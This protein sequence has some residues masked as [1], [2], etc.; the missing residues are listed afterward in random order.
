METCIIVA[1]FI[2]FIVISII[3]AYLNSPSVKGRRGELHVGNQLVTLP[4]EYIVLNDVVLPTRRGTTQIDHI[5]VSPYGIFGIE[6]KNYRGEIYGDDTREKWTQMIITDVTYRKSWKTYTYVTKSHFYNPVKQSLGHIYSLKD[7]LNDFGYIP[8]IPVVVFAGEAILSNVN[9]KYP[10]VYIE[11]LVSTIRCYDKR[12]LSGEQ[13]S[14]IVRRIS[15]I[16][17]RETVKNKDHIQNIRNAV[18]E[19]N[20]KVRNGICPRC[21]GQLVLRHGKYG[22]FYGCSNYPK[23]K[24]TSEA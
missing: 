14:E 5:V 1:L 23:C 7:C 2:G 12:Y 3:L 18:A 21:G 13:V 20:Q 9:S 8:M 19:K 10:V 15:S 17:V 16:N 22:S 24:F 6:T 4:N 11:N